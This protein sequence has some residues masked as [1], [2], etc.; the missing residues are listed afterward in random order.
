MGIFLDARIYGG[1]LEA[2]NMLDEAL[3]LAG[4]EPLAKIYDPD[5]IFLGDDSK[6]SSRIEQHEPGKGGI[7]QQ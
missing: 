1:I 4:R 7:Y 3:I 6:N 5:W 2:L